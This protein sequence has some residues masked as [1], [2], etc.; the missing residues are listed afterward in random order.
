MEQ[1][2][3]YAGYARVQTKSNPSGWKDIA[4]ADCMSRFRD[5]LKSSMFPTLNNPL[6]QH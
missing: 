3:K 4:N 1:H 6:K 2:A 5:S